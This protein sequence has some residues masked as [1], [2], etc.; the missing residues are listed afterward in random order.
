MHAFGKLLIFCIVFFCFSSCAIYTEK[1]TEAVSQTVYATKD[2]IDKARFDLADKYINETVRLINPPKARIEINYITE[3]SQSVKQNVQQLNIKSQGGTKKPSTE[4]RLPVV[5]IP[6]RLKGMSVIVVDSEEYNA[7]LEDKQ[8]FEQLK[9]DFENIAGAKATVDKEL[10]T[11]IKNRDKMI[12][13]LNKMK[14]V[15]SKKDL[16]IWKLSTALVTTSIALIAG[17]ILKFKGII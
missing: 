6:E 1:Q 16:T 2:S 4:T 9:I 17:V 14:E 12:R 3:P 13:D 10:Q 8:V 11:Q 15:L 5:V 7:L